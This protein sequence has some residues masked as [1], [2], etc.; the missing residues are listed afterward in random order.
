MGATYKDSR[1]NIQ[2]EEDF[3]DEEFIIKEN[4][5]GRQQFLRVTNTMRR[6]R[7]EENDQR[8]EHNKSLQELKQKVHA[9]LTSRISKELIKELLNFDGDLPVYWNHLRLQYGPTSEDSH[10]GDEGIHRPSDS[11]V[12][13]D[14]SAPGDDHE[15]ESMLQSFH[16]LSPSGSPYV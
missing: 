8:R 4:F 2:G 11:I 14:S 6:Q 16:R 5:Q 15:A 9:V 7:K 10:E 3:D 1:R 13:D 12:S